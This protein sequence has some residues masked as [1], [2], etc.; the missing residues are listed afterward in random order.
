M[1]ADTQTYKENFEIHEEVSLE[2]LA[3]TFKP[4]QPLKQESRH[5]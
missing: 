4:V 2:Q 1:I 3:A 5:T